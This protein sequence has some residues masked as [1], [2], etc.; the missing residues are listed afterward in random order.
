MQI[1]R[2]I[3]E[4]EGAELLMSLACLSLLSFRSCSEHLLQVLQPPQRISLRRFSNR[5]VWGIFLTLTGVLSLT[6]SLLHDK[7]R[8]HWTLVF[9]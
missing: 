9:Y 4:G 1:D 3:R 8:S 5:L 2:L 6:R 7:Q